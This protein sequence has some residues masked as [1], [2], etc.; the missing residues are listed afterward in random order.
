MAGKNFWETPWALFKACANRFG[1]IST[2]VCASHRNFKAPIYYTEDENGLTRD[3][4]KQK[5]FC[6]MNPP[7]ADADKKP[8]IGLWVQKAIDEAQK[9]ATVVALL[10]NDPSTKWFRL[11]HDHAAELWFLLGPRIRFE[12]NG[13][14]DGTSTQTH[15]IAVFRKLAPGEKR[16]GGFWDWRN[17]DSTDKHKHGEQTT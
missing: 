5:Y 17:S 16:K 3:W 1:E 8:V 4:H 10:V 9:G 6:W 15:V 7:Y 13:K 14:S 11:V 12:I 2:D